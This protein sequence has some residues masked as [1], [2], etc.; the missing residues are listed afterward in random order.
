CDVERDAAEQLTRPRAAEGFGEVADDQHGGRRGSA[1][2]SSRMPASLMTFVHLGISS[3]MRDASCCGGPP[4][5]C[6]PS[7]AIRLRTS[8][9]VMAFEMISFS[10][11]TIAGAVPRGARMPHQVEAS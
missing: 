1:G 11:P 3:R 6:A 2:Y 7:A 4:A 10:C 8:P 5:G 9:A